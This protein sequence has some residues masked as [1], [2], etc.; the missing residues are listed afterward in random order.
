MKTKTLLIAAA[1]LAAGIISS[2][3]QVYSQNIVGYAN[4]SAVLQVFTPVHDCCVGKSTKCRRDAM[5]RMVNSRAILTGQATFCWCGMV[6]GIILIITMVLVTGLMVSLL[7]QSPAP[8]AWCAI[9]GF[10]YHELNTGIRLF[11]KADHI[12]ILVHCCACRIQLPLIACW[13]ILW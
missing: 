10:F 9:L 2:Q 3:A 1:A 5:V 8:L 12:Y 4:R 7:T 11:T 13:V 6:V